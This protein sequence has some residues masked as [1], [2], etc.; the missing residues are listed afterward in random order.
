[1]AGVTLTP[2]LHKAYDY[3]D[4]SFYPKVRQIYNSSVLAADNEANRR[5]AAAVRPTL[6]STASTCEGW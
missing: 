4:C 3:Y 6:L 1:M 5:W 2:H